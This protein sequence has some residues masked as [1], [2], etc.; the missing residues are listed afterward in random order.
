MITNYNIHHMK[1]KNILSLTL[2]LC[3]CACNKSSESLTALQ[4]V[5]LSDPIQPIYLTGDSTHIRLADYV[6]TLS[7][8]DWDIA[9]FDIWEM[10]DLDKEVD[11]IMMKDDGNYVPTFTL[12]K[13]YKDFLSIVALPDLPT[14]S[15]LIC[16][17]C[18]EH[19]ISF[20]FK[21]EPKNPHFTILWQNIL[22]QLPDLKQ[23]AEGYILTIPTD[24]TKKGDSFIRIYA[25]DDDYLYNALLIPLQDMKPSI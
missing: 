23:T 5:M 19:T 13:D 4:K 8:A 6:P 20:A 25:A 10:C 24:H 21:E 12:G 1:I 15:G 18:T 11:L 17:G 22:L 7:T 3:L 9:Y 14:K 16:T 2:L